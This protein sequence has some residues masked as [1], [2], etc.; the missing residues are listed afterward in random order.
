MQEMFNSL[1]VSNNKNNELDF[2][3]DEPKSIIVT[4]EL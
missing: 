2:F 4:K 1:S 3:A